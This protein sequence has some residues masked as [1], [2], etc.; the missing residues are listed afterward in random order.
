MYNTWCGSKLCYMDVYRS[1]YYLG[2]CTMLL[3]SPDASLHLHVSKIS[4]ACE[5]RAVHVTSDLQE[6][7]FLNS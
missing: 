2:M 7:S 1:P 5:E 6:F 4:L 3:Y